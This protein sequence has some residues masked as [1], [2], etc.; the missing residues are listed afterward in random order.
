MIPDL[1]STPG[2][3]LVNEWEAL[4]LVSSTATAPV[5]A[6][7]HGVAVRTVARYRA[8]ARRPFRCVHCR[9]TFITRRAAWAH[10]LGDDR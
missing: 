6:A 8:R 5:L 3:A 4:E 10:L 7:A 2:S 1:R 9:A